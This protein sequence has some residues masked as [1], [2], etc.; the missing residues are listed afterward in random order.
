MHFMKETGTFQSAILLTST[1]S[2]PMTV[3]WQEELVPERQTT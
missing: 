1:I 2:G 3:T